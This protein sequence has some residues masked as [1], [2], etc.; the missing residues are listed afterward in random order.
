MINLPFYQSCWHG[1]DLMTLQKGKYS[2]SKKVADSILYEDLYEALKV[3][4]FALSASWVED[5]IKLSEWIKKII[6]EYKPKTSSILSVGCG[7]GIVEEELIKDGFKIDLQ[8]CQSSSLEFAKNRLKNKNVKFIISEDLSACNTN[9]YNVVMAITS[10]YC[11]DEATLEKFLQSVAR[12]LKK[13]GVFIWY[14]TCLTWQDI[15]QYVK[16]RI[17]SHIYHNGKQNGILWGWK[18]SLPAQ[19]KLA[20][21]YGFYLDK[22]FYLTSTNE[23]LE[24]P[25]IIFGV[26]LGENL[27]WQTGVY[28]CQK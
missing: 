12:I 4:K 7:L 9:S 5:K 8:E 6:L 11:L 16:T 21:K 26:P 3:R 10:T 25:R 28:K 15:W 22:S 13:D 20:S 19:T 17:Y 14:E 23:C 27:I 24:N 18:R 2:N 1:I